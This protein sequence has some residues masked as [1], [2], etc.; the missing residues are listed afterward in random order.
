VVKMPHEFAKIASVAKIAIE[1]LQ[2]SLSKITNIGKID[3]KDMVDKIPELG[4][5]AHCK[6]CKMNDDTALIW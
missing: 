5:T 4:K 3:I 1:E 2:T 6:T